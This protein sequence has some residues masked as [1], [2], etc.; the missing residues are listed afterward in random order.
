MKYTLSFVVIDC[1][2]TVHDRPKQ[3]D[4]IRHFEENTS[5]F[6]FKQLSCLIS[7]ENCMIPIIKNYFC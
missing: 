3:I 4:Q 6:H 1:S 5:N 2:N 7:F